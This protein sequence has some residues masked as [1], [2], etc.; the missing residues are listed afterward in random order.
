MNTT[1]PLRVP[2]NCSAY[3]FPHRVRGGKCHELFPV[4]ANVKSGDMEDLAAL[5]DR[6]EAAAINQQ[7]ERMN[8]L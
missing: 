6:E 7:R 1:N 3:A 4:V 2:C 5:F 8:A